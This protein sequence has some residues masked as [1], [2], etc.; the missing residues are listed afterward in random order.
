MLFSCL[1]PEMGNVGFEGDV[2]GATGKGKTNS[3]LR[4]TFR[5]RLNAEFRRGPLLGGSR[6]STT[7]ILV[8]CGS[9]PELPRPSTSS[10]RSMYLVSWNYL[11]WVVYH[12]VAASMVSSKPLPGM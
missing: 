8:A 7:V 1:G 6:R 9:P 5:V 2:R 10:R 11:R 3:A 4:P 12:L